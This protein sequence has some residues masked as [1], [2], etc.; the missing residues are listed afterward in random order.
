MCN[1]FMIVFDNYFLKK[2]HLPLIVSI[3]PHQWFCFL[4]FGLDFDW[5]SFFVTVETR[6]PIKN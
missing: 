2:I 6:Q 5:L 3:V 4:I 1:L